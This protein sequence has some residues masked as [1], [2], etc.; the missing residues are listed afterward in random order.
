[1]CGARPTESKAAQNLGISLVT[2]FTFSGSVF[3]EWFCCAKHT[4]HKKIDSIGK[5]K[6]FIVIGLVRLGLIAPMAKTHQIEPK[7]VTGQRFT[8]KAIAEC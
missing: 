8:K 4:M 5:I 7:M 3:L 2:N 6:F 1:M